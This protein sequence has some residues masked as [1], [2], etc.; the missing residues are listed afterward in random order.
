ML[1]WRHAN[2]G[3][4]ILDRRHNNVRMKISAWM[5]TNVPPWLACIHANMQALVLPIP[6]PIIQIKQKSRRFAPAAPINIL[7][8]LINRNAVIGSLP[9]LE[10]KRWRR[11]FIRIV[12]H[13]I[14]VGIF[15]L[16][17]TNSSNRGLR[18]AAI[19]FTLAF[20]NAY[21]Y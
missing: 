19:N 16:Y 17:R 15:K 7:I 6:L 10:V 14:A 3:E 21:R 13:T 1:A 8:K 4:K 2:A 12:D 20:K 18:G 11:C 9:R 5:H